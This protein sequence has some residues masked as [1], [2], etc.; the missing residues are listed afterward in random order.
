MELSL[1]FQD[2]IITPLCSTMKRDPVFEVGYASDMVVNCRKGSNLDGERY[3]HQC[4]K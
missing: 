4:R 2:L 1:R 3:C